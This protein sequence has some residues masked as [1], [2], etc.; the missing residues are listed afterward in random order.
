MAMTQREAEAMVADVHVLLDEK[1]IQRIRVE[2]PLIQSIQKQAKDLADEFEQNHPGLPHP[3]Y[4]EFVKESFAQRTGIRLPDG[5][6][7]G[8]ERLRR[9]QAA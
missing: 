3:S 1:G 7:L 8:F 9:E 6:N 2:G 5:A 4:F